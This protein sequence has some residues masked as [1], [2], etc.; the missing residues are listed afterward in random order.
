MGATQI[1]AAA[2]S[3][4]GDPTGE[5]VGADIEAIENGAAATIHAPSGD[6][7]R[8]AV[9]WL[10]DE[11][12]AAASAGYRLWV[13]EDRCTLVRMWDSGKVE[14]ARRNASW[15]TWGPP[16]VLTEEKVS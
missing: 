12:A 15:E 10:G 7:Y 3:G 1:L 13:S 16:V 4:V 11:E 5:G 9:E 14:V 6:T 2:L 8:V